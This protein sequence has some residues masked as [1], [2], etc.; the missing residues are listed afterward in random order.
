MREFEAP[1]SCGKTSWYFRWFCAEPGKYIV[2]FD[3]G[4]WGYESF[5]A[6]VDDFGDLIKR[7]SDGLKVTAR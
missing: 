1:V 6:I 3:Y 4:H 7:D 2:T 5:N